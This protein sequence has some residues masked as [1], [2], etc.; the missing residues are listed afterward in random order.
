V[1]LEYHFKRELKQ[2]FFNTLGQLLKTN[3]FVKTVEIILVFLIAFLFIKL[4]GSNEESD[5]LYNQ[6]VI[7]FAN[8]IMLILVFT[9]IKLRGEGLSHFGIS[10][11]KVTWKIGFK[12]FLQSI[13]VSILAITGFVIGSIL[14]G[15]HYRY[16]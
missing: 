3:K 10:F 12:T 4:F 6:A 11:K 15:K 8:I 1:E 13:V 9:G 7:W 16:S 14:M 2:A 5:L